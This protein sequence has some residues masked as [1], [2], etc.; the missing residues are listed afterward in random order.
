MKPFDPTL[1]RTAPAARRPVAVLAV[2]GV[3]QGLATIALTVAVAA[4]VV[5]VVAHGSLTGPASWLAGLFLLRA[6]LAWAGERLAAH[7]GVEVT[8]ALRRALLARWLTW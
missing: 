3:V 2:V 8:V 6:G 4:T 1:L 7:A 5:A